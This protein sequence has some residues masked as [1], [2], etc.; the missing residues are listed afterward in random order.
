MNESS[1][2]GGEVM[3][4]GIDITGAAW[5]QKPFSSASLI[6]KIDE[7]P[8][9]PRWNPRSA[10][11]LVALEELSAL[12]QSSGNGRRNLRAVVRSLQ[13]AKPDLGRPLRGQARSTGSR[14]NRS[15]LCRSA[16]L[17]GVV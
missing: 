8:T 17:T 2:T 6:A 11:S 10:S 3:R 16:V 4:H 9:S 13:N 5:L 12:Q 1:F 14:G 7:M 15:Y